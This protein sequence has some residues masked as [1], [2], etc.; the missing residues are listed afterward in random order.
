MFLPWLLYI[1]FYSI[2]VNTNASECPGPHL[3]HPA[4]SLLRTYPP[5]RCCH[6]VLLRALRTVHASRCVATPR[7]VFPAL[8]LLAP[9]D[10][11]SG[12]ALTVCRALFSLP[13]RLALLRVGPRRHRA[14]HHR[15]HV[16][17]A[18]PVSHC[19][20]FSTP[21]CVVNLRFSSLSCVA[22]CATLCVGVCR[23][24]HKAACLRRVPCVPLAPLGIELALLGSRSTRFSSVIV[25]FL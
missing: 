18:P 5:I 1:V 23:C 10:M 11:H 6:C 14:D 25:P 19:D 7:I 9:A 20:S 8:L 16:P 24:C 21:A 15:N 22:S 4:L 13:R 3:I 2:G 17:P 12:C